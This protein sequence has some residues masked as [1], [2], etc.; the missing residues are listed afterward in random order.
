[1]SGYGKTADFKYFIAGLLWNLCQNVHLP[2]PQYQFL[3]DLFCPPLN[4]LTYNITYRTFRANETCVKTNKYRVSQNTG[5]V[6]S[7]FWPLYTHQSPH[8]CLFFFGFN[9]LRLEKLLYQKIQNKRFVLL[10]VL[11]FLILTKSLLTRHNILKDT[12]KSI[13]LPAT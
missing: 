9:G 12:V 13:Q 3:W 4:C 5:N 10:M 7:S 1:M 11:L 2:S 6:R 8:V